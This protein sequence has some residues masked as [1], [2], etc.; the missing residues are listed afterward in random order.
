MKK[1]EYLDREC[2][3]LREDP[4]PPTGW[5]G[6]EEIL[7]VAKQH[8]FAAERAGVVWDPEEPEVLWV[9]GAEP[10]AQRVRADGSME[11]LQGNCRDEPPRWQ[12]MVMTTAMERELARRLLEE[13]K[14]QEALDDHNDKLEEAEASERA[15]WSVMKEHQYRLDALD[16]RLGSVKADW[17]RHLS[18]LGGILDRLRNLEQDLRLVRGQAAHVD[19]RK[20]ALF[21][22][23]GLPRESFVQIPRAR[24]D[25]LTAL[26]KLWGP[27]GEL[28]AKLVDIRNPGEWLAWPH[29][30]ARFASLRSE[31]LALPDEVK[32]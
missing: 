29:G 27:E 3:L 5:C 14:Q 32:S 1:S 31:L 17:R 22:D 7:M 25:K 16:R 20:P 8:A 9:S 15:A 23:I 19:E 2:E 18:I 21:D 10:G 13:H 24:F 12:P 26:E 11:Y 6:E 4:P 30:V 28:R